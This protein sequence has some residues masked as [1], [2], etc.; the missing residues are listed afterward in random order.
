MNI[1]EILPAIIAATTAIVW[2]IR[3]EG[4]IKNLKSDLDHSLTERDKTEKTLQSIDGKLE[5]L[6]LTMTSYHTEIALIKQELG[7]VLPK[8][9][10]VKK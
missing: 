1:N 6:R 7:F 3:L 4:Q 8:K 10:T 9:R 2:L 5:A